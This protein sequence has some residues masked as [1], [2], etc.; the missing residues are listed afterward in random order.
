MSTNIITEKIVIQANCSHGEDD[1]LPKFS[2]QTG[3]N[4]TEEGMQIGSQNNSEEIDL[5]KFS[6]DPKLLLYCSNNSF[7]IQDIENHKGS[8]KI[9]DKF[10]SNGLVFEIFTYLKSLTLAK[11]N[12]SEFGSNVKRS[13]F[14]SI[15]IFVH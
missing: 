8:C 5:A 6:F 2:P 15:K 14:I 3:Q 12:P 7:N 13:L 1:I 11:K 9:S 10:L 4:Q